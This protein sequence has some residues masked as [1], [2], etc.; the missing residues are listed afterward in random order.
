MLRLAEESEIR[1]IRQIVHRHIADFHNV[2]PAD[3]Y[4]KRFLFKPFAAANGTVRSAHIALYIPFD[5][6]GRS[7]VISPLQVC[8]ETFPRG[9]I[10]AR[11]AEC[12]VFQIDF[13]PAVAEHQHIVNIFGQILNGHVQRKTVD[14]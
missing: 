1:K 2:F 13:F 14:L 6:F 7:L 9:F 8:D 10:T 12:V 3:G 5:A 4:G 11:K